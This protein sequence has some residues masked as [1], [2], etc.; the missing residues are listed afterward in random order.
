MFSICPPPQ[1]RSRHEALQKLAIFF[2]HNKDEFA[3]VPDNVG[4]TPTKYRRLLTLPQQ[5][6]FSFFF[7]LSSSL[8]F[9]S[10]IPSIPA[11]VL[12]QQVSAERCS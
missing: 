4:A 6:T 3:D 12:K 1:S 11:K 10:F 5:S 8:L 2:Q 7:P 9:P